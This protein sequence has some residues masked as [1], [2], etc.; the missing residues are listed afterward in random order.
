MGEQP[1]PLNFPLFSFRVR[2]NGQSKQIFDFVRKRF[3][4]LTPEEWVRQHLLRFLTDQYRYPASLLAV[5]KT[6]KVNSLSQRADVVVYDRS[7]LP[8][9]IVECKAPSV[10]ISR[11]T[12]YQAARYNLSLKVPFFVL[13]NGKEHF[14]LEFNGSELF[15]RDTL[16]VFPS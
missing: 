7:G 16:P 10:P 11:E 3:V 8:W 14:C 15:F 13:T 2:D 6:V 1:E 5:E 12:F 9:M 4:P